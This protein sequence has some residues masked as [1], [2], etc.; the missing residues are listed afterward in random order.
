MMGIV[1]GAESPCKPVPRIAPF[2]LLSIGLLPLVASACSSPA[3]APSARG[4]LTASAAAPGAAEVDEARIEDLAAAEERREREFLAE[5][6]A[7]GIHPVEEPAQATV[8]YHGQDLTIGLYNEGYVSQ[9]EF[10]SVPRSS[11]N[12]K[13]VPNIQMGALW[14]ALEDLGFFAAARS[15]IVR[16]PGASVSVVLRRG[17]DSWTLSWGPDMGTEKYDVTM[18]SAKAVQALFNSAFGM[19]VV[20]NP[21]GADYFERERERLRQNALRRGVS[22]Q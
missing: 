10:Y 21:D 12:Y 22:D 13:V 17:G 16:T 14:K 19:Q 5:M 8:K 18:E 15:G 6:A 11:A 3:A 4:S 9:S 1:P 7:Q 20:D 2:L